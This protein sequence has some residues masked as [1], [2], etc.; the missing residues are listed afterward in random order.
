VAQSGFE[1]EPLSEPRSFRLTGSLDVPSAGHLTELLD[2]LVRE[3]GDVR[4][5]LT[6]VTFMDSSGLR[7]LIQASMDLGDRGKIRLRH[8]N[9]QIRRLLQMSGAQD[10]LANLVIEADPADG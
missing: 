5:D 3:E 4:L 7:A 8:P 6:G 10:S 1:V 2:E 9:E